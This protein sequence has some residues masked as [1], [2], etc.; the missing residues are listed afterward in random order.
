MLDKVHTADP[1]FDYRSRDDPVCL[2]PATAAA[3]RNI[4]LK[5]SDMFAIKR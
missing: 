1:I 2:L 3:A 5:D 4:F